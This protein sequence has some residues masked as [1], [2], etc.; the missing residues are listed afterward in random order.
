MHVAY[1]LPLQEIFLCW[2]VDVDKQ[3]VEPVFRDRTEDANKFNFRHLPIV[4]SFG[5]KTRDVAEG[6]WVS[7]DKM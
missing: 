2:K 4:I 5:C 6:P 1:D 7:E 3:L